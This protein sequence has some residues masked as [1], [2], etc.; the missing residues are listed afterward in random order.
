MRRLRRE[1]REARRRRVINL[2]RRGRT[3]DEIA[4]HT[5]VSRT[6]VF[7][8]CARTALEGAS[9]YRDKPSGRSANRARALTEPPAIQ[10]RVLLRA[11]M[12]DRREM[13]FA[14][15]TRHAVRE[16]GGQR[17]ALTLTLQGGPV[18]GAPGVLA[19]KAVEAGVRAAARS[20]VGDVERDKSWLG[21]LKRLCGRGERRQAARP[22]EAADQRRA[23]Q[24][25][26]SDAQPS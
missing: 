23:Q 10:I 2:R 5:N 3:Y 8:I 7:D 21:A 16:S 12:P 13:P 19:A 6:G 14:W 9:A 4:A 20:S 11:P 15:C 1:A 25:N 17:R 26:V 22:P 18:S 24:Q